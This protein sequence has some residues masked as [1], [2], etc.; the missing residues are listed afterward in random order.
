MLNAWVA[1]QGT[2]GTP[3]RV[4]LIINQPVWN[5]INYL[6]RY[7]FLNQF[8]TELRQDG[9]SVRVFNRQADLLGAYIC[10]PAAD[11]ARQCSIEELSS[12]GRG[13]FGGRPRNSLIP[14]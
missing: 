2:D 3:R 7:T 8:G 9:Y 12:T 10:E 14:R 4:D 6:Q 11:T 13:A 1:H 5:A